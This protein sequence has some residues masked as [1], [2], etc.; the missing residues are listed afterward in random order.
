MNKEQM[1]K[2]IFGLDISTNISES[3]CVLCHKEAKSFKDDLSKKEYLISGMCQECQ[4]N[5][6]L[7][8]K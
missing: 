1:I 5:V 8:N 4:D 3:K 2:N 7:D 6:F